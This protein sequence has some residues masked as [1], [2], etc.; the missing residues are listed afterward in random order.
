M[1]KADGEP[2]P[3]SRARRL[4]E[5]TRLEQGLAEI[6][7][8]VRGVV[9]DGSVSADEAE[10]LA[11]WTRENPDVAV[12]WPV[13]LLHRRLEHIFRDGRVDSAE[14][15]HLGAILGQLA[16]NPAGLDLSLATDL[17]LDRPQPEVL[18]EGRTFVF[19]GELAFGPQRAC[20][21][22]VREL[23]G[24]TE[25]TVSR[26][27][28]YLVL[29]S[30]GGDDWSQSSYGALIDE[31]VQYRMRGVPVAVISEEHWAEALP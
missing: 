12:R 22:E 29:G 20:E 27:T 30:L 11:R 17:P 28:D 24:Q 5:R 1:T 3:K 26:R 21:R 14:R 8:I 9:A 13:N 31:V 10:R 23:G 4:Q 25:R 16:Q 15:R 2:T 6:V 18:F 7:G 19:A